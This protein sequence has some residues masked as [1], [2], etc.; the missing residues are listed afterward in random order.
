MGIKKT[1]SEGTPGTIASYDFEDI[2][3]NTGI[4]KFYAGNTSGG[5]ILSNN[6]FWSLASYTS[7]TFNTPNIISGTLII[8][9]DF[10]VLFNRQSVIRGKTNINVPFGVNMQHG[11]S[12][13]RS[14]IIAKV[15]KWDGT[16][17][18]EI[19]SG[20]SPIFAGQG[21]DTITAMFCIEVDIPSTIIKA[22]EYLR[23]TIEQYAGGPGATANAHG[24]Y[25]FAHDPKGRDV[26]FWS[27]TDYGWAGDGVSTILT[28]PVPFRIDL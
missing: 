18:T 16:T 22:G 13:Y 19:A 5:A 1:Y 27:D 24:I 2:A 9:K 23:L 15:R 3:T 6:E 25:F 28:F 8:D 20:Q 21:I 12:Q 17:E 4:V 7:N 11:G 14:Y 26:T 10:D